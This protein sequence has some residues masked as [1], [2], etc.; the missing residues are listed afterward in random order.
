MRLLGYL[1]QGI[2][3]RRFLIQ[4]RKRYRVREIHAGQMQGWVMAILVGLNVIGCSSVTKPAPTGAPVILP[5]FCADEQQEIER[6]QK[7]LAEKEVQQNEIERL[8]KLLAEK[9][10]QIRAQQARQQDQ[11][12]TLQETSSQAAHARVKLRRLATRPAAASTIAEVEIALENLK[13]SPLT[14]TEQTLSMQA[15]RLLDAAAT[16]YS[17]D[18][19]GTVMDHA[20]QAGEF[21]DMVKNNRLRKA[22]DPHLVTVSL[23]IPILMRAIAN[24]NLRHKPALGGMVVSVLQKGSLITSEAY[25]GDWLLVQ[26]A[27]GR[28]GWVLNTLVEVVVEKP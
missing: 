24:A 14:T 3:V 1:D 18:N 27:D 5:V 25:R 11:A 16:S 12:K 15:K 21:I 23:Q 10:A 20:A 9:E 28:S 7:S 22:S 8:Q 6:L 2:K 19:Y 26:T 13:S 17:E 4:V